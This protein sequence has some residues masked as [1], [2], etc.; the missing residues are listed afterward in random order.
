[1]TL[2]PVAGI[3]EA[4]ASE[5]EGRANRGPALRRARRLGELLGEASGGGGAVDQRPVDHHH[6]VVRAGPFGV[7]DGD[8]L[9]LA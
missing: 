1:M 5:G 3:I 6:L 7:A 2:G 8:A 9:V 4:L